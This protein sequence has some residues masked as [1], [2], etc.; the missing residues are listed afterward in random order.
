MIKSLNQPQKCKIE[1]KS[2]IITL[3]YLGEKKKLLV[4]LEACLSK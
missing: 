1:I 3:I 4:E 2:K